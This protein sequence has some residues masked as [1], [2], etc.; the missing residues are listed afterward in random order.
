MELNTG[1]RELTLKI[2]YYGPALSGKTTNLQQLHGALDPG[3]AGRLMSLDTRGDRTLFFDLLPIHFRTRTGLRVKIKLFTVPGQVVHESTRK[4]VLAGAD[5]VVFIADSQRSMMSENNA[6]FRNLH[7]NMKENGLDIEKTPV[8]IQFNKRDLPVAEILTEE[9][10]EALAR[11]GKEPVVL[12]A[13]LRGDGVT[14][15][16]KRVLELLFKH[17][18]AQY[19]FGRK[20]GLKQ[21][22][23]IENLFPAEGTQQPKTEVAR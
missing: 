12:A 14:E 22:D 5:A 7:K 8:I 6:S 11:R 10:I 9:E 16:L 15:T 1:Q 4:L 17:L 3:N 18:D 19:H 23:F 13:A 21:R 2:V 20:F